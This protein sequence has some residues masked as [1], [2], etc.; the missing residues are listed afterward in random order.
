[1]DYG[2]VLSA[3]EDHIVEAHGDYGPELRIG[4]R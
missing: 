2:I 1:M 4:F 3:V